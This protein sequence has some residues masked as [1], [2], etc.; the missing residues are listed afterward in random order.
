MTN[1]KVLV[2]VV[3]LNIV[4]SHRTASSVKAVC[5][6][7][8]VMYFSVFGNMKIVKSHIRRWKILYHGS[9]TSPTGEVHFTWPSLIFQFQNV[10]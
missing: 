3:M 5:H 1:G 10:A 6:M 8:L 4:T 9:Q 2:T 7:E